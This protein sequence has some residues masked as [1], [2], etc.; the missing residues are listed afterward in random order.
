MSAGRPP[1]P[2]ARLRRV[3][4]LA[5]L[6]P[7]LLVAAY[8][9][10][11]GLMLHDNAA[12]R[13]AF[14]RGDTDGAAAE[15]AGTRSLNLFEPWIAPFDEGASWHAE[16]NYPS[17][18]AAYLAALEHVPRREECTVRINLALAYEAIGDEAQQA[19]ATSR[20]AE[21]WQAGIDTLAEG[22]C[23][24]DAG[25][26][27]E[28]QSDAGAVDERLRGKLKQSQQQ[29]QPEQQPQQPDDKPKDQ[30]DPK[31]DR[32]EDNNQR[33]LG[34]RHEDQDLYQDEDATKPDTW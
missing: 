32:L 13:D 21:A 7:A 5:G 18:V 8:A 20:A 12:G 10:K 26:G 31:R 11:V 2:R 17:A 25:G 28:Q 19:G 14:V 30:P 29:P 15:F 23:P 1:Y 6:L 33:G 24:T 3:L 22:K 4:L 34:Q 16:G 27:E 9:V